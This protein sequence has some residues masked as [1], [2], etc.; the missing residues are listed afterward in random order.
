LIG[1]AALVCC[2]KASARSAGLQA[3][4]AH[5]AAT[6]AGK[7]IASVQRLSPVVSYGGWA[8]WSSYDGTARAYQLI[9]RSPTGVVAAMGEPQ[10]GRP[11]EVSLGPLASGGVGAVFAHCGEPTDHRGCVLEQLAIETS[12][13]HETQLPVPGAGSFFRPALW[14]GTI[15]FLRSRSSA[16]RLAASELLE[17]TIGANRLTRLALPS[18]RY[19]AREIEE[20]PEVRDTESTPGTITALTL[21]GT[22]VAYVR[23]APW[24]EWARSDIWVQSPGQRAKVID[25]IGTGGAS[26]GTRT[27]LSP[28]ILNGWL[29]AYRQYHELGEAWVRFKLNADTT[30]KA[31]VDLGDTSQ[32]LVQAAAPLNGGLIWSSQNQEEGLAGR[33]ARIL[34][35]ADVTWTTLRDRPSLGSWAAAQEPR[36]SSVG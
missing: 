21:N 20:Q 14:K 18:N 19:Y 15:A 26:D 17:W 1:F 31:A 34:V 30:Q 29:Y 5:R 24:G 2:A 10:P 3:Q 28:V 25:W 23:V 27:F 35:Q 6:A 13:P 9:V 7:A 33:G 4:A 16:G 12:D 22:Q 32:G 11:F 36:R 8:A